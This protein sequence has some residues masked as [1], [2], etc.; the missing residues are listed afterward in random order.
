M[1]TTARSC[2]RWGFGGLL[3]AFLLF[4]TGCSQ[5]SNPVGIQVDDLAPESGPI[6]VELPD[7]ALAPGH[8]P[9]R[10]ML[11]KSS[12]NV[13]VYTFDDLAV[14]CI[15]NATFPTAY[16]DLTFSDSRF[17]G[18]CSYGG[19][20]ALVAVDYAKLNSGGSTRSLISLPAPATAVSIEAYGIRNY[21]PRSFVAYDAAGVEIDRASFTGTNLAM[22]LTVTGTIHQVA[23]IDYQTQ[24]Y[25]DNLTV[26]YG[27]LN[28][29]PV[30]DAGPD[31]QIIVS[32]AVT[33]DGTASSD[34]NGD[35]LMYAWSMVA[36]PA[37]SQAAFSSPSSA[38]T[39][40]TAD[41][42]GTY[43]VQ[44]VVSDGTTESAPDHVVLEVIGLP[45]ALAALA[46]EVS[47]LFEQG[48][49]SRP[50]SASL[51]RTLDFIGQKLASQPQAAL[52]M[53]NGFTG[54]VSGLVNGRVLTREQGDTLI[55]YAQR[56][57]AAGQGAIGP[58]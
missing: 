28:D 23:I 18:R 5:S 1:A 32:E 26:S 3:I 46:E 8:A 19:G 2:A 17:L 38:V 13:V 20:V 9:E 10:S 7:E 53:L 21:G 52:K 33:L 29:P 54:H 40:V 24:T 35:A 50:Q 55:G 30:A 36:T 51:L 44:L 43:T 56:I 25:W 34:P 27:S 39:T 11:A 49:L 12:E 42:P 4:V 45:D 57:A 16:Q 15:M 22:W 31:Q 37:G 14:S 48:T 6:P 41:L 58:S 47:A